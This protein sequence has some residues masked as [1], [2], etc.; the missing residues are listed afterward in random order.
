MIRVVNNGIRPT[1]LPQMQLRERSS[2]WI[3]DNKLAI[4]PSEPILGLWKQAKGLRDTAALD[5]SYAP[6]LLQ[7]VDLLLHK[8]AAGD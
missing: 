8:A 3:C 4:R 7:L 2:S 6:G 5:S 1:K